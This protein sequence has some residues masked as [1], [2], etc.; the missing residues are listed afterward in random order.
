MTGFLI[1]LNGSKPFVIIGATISL[2]SICLFILSLVFIFDLFRSL[3]AN[4]KGDEMERRE[5]LLRLNILAYK[6]PMQD[7]SSMR[8]RLA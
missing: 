2:C 7:E 1:I 6:H 4:I 8:M 5:S 3:E